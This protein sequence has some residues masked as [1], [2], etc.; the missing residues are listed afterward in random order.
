MV[1]RLGVNNRERSEEVGV[2]ND[3]VLRIVVAFQMPDELVDLA[4]NSGAS[5]P[6]YLCQPDPRAMSPTCMSVKSSPTD[7]ANAMRPS[8]NCALVTLPVPST[9]YNWNAAVSSIRYSNLFDPSDVAD[10]S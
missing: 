2:V 7:R 8:R 1:A 9:S 4:T 3:P 5:R 6:H 10:Q